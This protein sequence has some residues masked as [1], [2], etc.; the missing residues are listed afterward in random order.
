MNAALWQ[1]FHLFRSSKLYSSCLIFV[2]E[3]T[4]THTWWRAAPLVLSREDYDTDMSSLIMESD[5]RKHTYTHTLEVWLRCLPAL[6]PPCGK[7]SFPSSFCHSS[8]SF[9]PSPPPFI[10]SFSVCDLS[11]CC[12][13]ITS[14]N[15]VSP[16]SFF[17]WISYILYLFCICARH[18]T[19]QK[20]P[21][22]FSDSELK[23]PMRMRLYLISLLL[24]KFSKCD[25]CY[26]AKLHTH[27][28]VQ[29]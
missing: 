26:T 29:A 13:Q 7:P 18:W 5:R 27:S 1:T 19:N 11:S 28:A 21:R 17:S 25:N 20:S 6:G 8:P 3:H 2:H 24:S 10:S 4:H 15:Y 23:Y 16:H 22:D 12:N 14:S 9:S